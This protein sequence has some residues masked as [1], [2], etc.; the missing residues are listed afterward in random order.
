VIKGG[1][2]VNFI[3]SPDEHPGSA[4]ARFGRTAWWQASLAAGLALAV[5][6]RPAPTATSPAAGRAS[7]GEVV[8]YT[9]L[10]REFS[11]PVFE[12]FTQIT[13]IQVRAKYDTEANKTVGLANLIIN[14]RAR[15][16]CDL[17]WN[18][19]ILNTLRLQ[20]EGLLRP[21]G[22]N[23]ADAYPPMYRS[24]SEHWYGFAARARI[25]LV[26]KDRVPEDQWPTSI[27]DL[28]DPKWRN[29]V[30]IANPLFGTTATHGA[31]LFAQWGADEAQSFFRAIRE[32]AQ[33]LP[34]NRQ[35]SQAVG[36]GRV[37]FGL[38]DTDDGVIEVEQGNPVAIIYPDQEEGGLGTLFIPNTLGLIALSPNGTHAEKLLN[39]LLSPAVEQQ[40]AE[41]RSAQIPL[42]EGG[43]SSDRV[44]TPASVR[45]ME[46]DFEAAAAKWDEAARFFE[47]EFR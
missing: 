6:C 33:I 1:Q 39:F 47:E 16:R 15:P 5:G 43:Q 32:N 30:A 8:V 19:E 20:R 18:N 40:L 41:G 37:A 7:A 14:E 9:A 26:N 3:Q 36:A 25:L 42:H 22:S 11:E 38:T 27:R 23:W 35:V 28:A 2:V 45:P 44:Q 31:C 17:F 46:V 24:P 13:G 29:Q 34:G 12:E 21:F 10:D 4:G